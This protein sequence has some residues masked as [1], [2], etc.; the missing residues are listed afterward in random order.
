MGFYSDVL[1]RSEAQHLLSGSRADTMRVNGAM[2]V[3][4]VNGSANRAA[5]LLTDPGETI[6]LKLFPSSSAAA[7]GE[8]SR[9]YHSVRSMCK[10]QV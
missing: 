3:P 1:P 10:A 4:V 6:E 5:A 2:A 8:V 7:A 9:T